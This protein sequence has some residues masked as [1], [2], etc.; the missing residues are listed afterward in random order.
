M[1]FAGIP[2]LL[3]ATNMTSLA[4]RHRGDVGS[5]PE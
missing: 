1:I 3:L 4:A 2:S 5:D